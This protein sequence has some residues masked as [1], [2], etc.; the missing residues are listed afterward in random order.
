MKTIDKWIK[1]GHTLAV[2]ASE[3]P[4]FHG[5]EW[6]DIRADSGK[7]YMFHLVAKVSDLEDNLLYWLYSCTSNDWQLRVLND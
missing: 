4:D 2:E 6:V 1:V 7:I 3:L 5:Q